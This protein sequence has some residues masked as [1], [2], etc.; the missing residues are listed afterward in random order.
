MLSLIDL[1]DFV[2][3][4]ILEKLL[5][6]DIV[7]LYYVCRKFR[8]IIERHALFKRSLDL[9]LVGHRNKEA[10]AYQR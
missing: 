6:D 10:I 3:T 5:L 8:T 2:L 1:N 9:L 7:N 4:I